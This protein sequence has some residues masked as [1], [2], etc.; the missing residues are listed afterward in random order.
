MALRIEEELL[1]EKI[2]GALG[3]DEDCLGFGRHAPLVFLE[4]HHA[5]QVAAD[6][7]RREQRGREGDVELV[8]LA[9][10][11]V[12]LGAGRARRRERRRDLARRH[13]P[14]QHG[15]GG[16]QRL[17][18]FPAEHLDIEG[19]RR[20]DRLGDARAQHE[21][22]GDADRGAHGARAHRRAGDVVR[23]QEARRATA[24]RP[25]GFA[26]EEGVE[27]PLPFGIVNDIGLVVE[28]HL[29]AGDLAGEVDAADHVERRRRVAGRRD[30]I[31]RRKRVGD[32]LVALVDRDRRRRAFLRPEP[33]GAA[34]INRL[35][36]LGVSRS[37]SLPFS[38]DAEET[39]A[40]AMSVM[41]RRKAQSKSCGKA[42]ARHMIRRVPTFSRFEG[43]R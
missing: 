11:H 22:G 29:G 28:H 35:H 19:R 17:P 1:A 42:T 7:G 18:G 25:T 26:G 32:H 27:P 41:H 6:G 34:R 15:A 39:Q 12:E 8:V 14:A 21:R 37:R 4:I 23:L 13:L 43:R 40:T 24:H 31:E 20:S 10:R 3:G 16:D 30:D 5:D 33:V 38:A 36:D 2:V 9:E